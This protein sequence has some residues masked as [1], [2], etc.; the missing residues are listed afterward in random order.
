MGGIANVHFSLHS[1]DKLTGL[2]TLGLSKPA[3]GNTQSYVLVA[4][5]GKGKGVD[6]GLPL[7][8]QSLMSLHLL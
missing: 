3:T 6:S 5:L 4:N 8:K 1:L 2:K 7:T